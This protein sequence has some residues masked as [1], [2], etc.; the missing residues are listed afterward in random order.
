MYAYAAQSVAGDP[1]RN[2]AGTR[3]KLRHCSCVQKNKTSAM[4]A[5]WSSWT[6]EIVPPPTVVRYN[7]N[8]VYQQHHWPEILVISGNT[9]KITVPNTTTK[10]NA[11]GHEL[12]ASVA[13]TPVEDGQGDA[14]SLEIRDEADKFMTLRPS[15]C[16]LDVLENVQG[17][18]NDESNATAMD[19][20]RTCY[21][22]IRHIH[23]VRPTSDN[24]CA[25]KETFRTSKERY[26]SGNQS[27][28]I[29]NPK[30]RDNGR[31]SVPQNKNRVRATTGQ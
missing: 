1:M 7:Q 10:Y 6:I 23:P 18:V 15:V 12:L 30:R 20:A 21:V 11:V 27:N 26:D 8:Q 9:E 31:S 5:V 19:G 24:I 17:L 2:F 4:G 28:L 14:G 22:D 29:S 13:Q 3:S 25:P 16:G